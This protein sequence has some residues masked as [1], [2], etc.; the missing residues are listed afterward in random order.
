VLEKQRPVYLVALKIYPGRIEFDYLPENTQGVICQ[1]IG[2]QGVLILG[3]NAPRSYTKQEENWIAGIADKL[4]VT[5]GNY[6]HR[7]D[8]M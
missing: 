7:D 6:L 1:P 8:A 2:Q 4:D 3:A 5:F